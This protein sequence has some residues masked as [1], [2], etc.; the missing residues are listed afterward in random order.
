MAT[1]YMV[2]GFAEK[3]LDFMESDFLDLI[4]SMCLP[5]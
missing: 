3:I 5:I 4:V 2:Q 1:W